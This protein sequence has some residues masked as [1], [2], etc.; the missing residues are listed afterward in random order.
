MLNRLVMLRT[1]T[2]QRLERRQRRGRTR[3]LRIEHRGRLAGTQIKN[4]RN[5]HIGRIRLLMRGRRRRIVEQIRH[6]R[7]ERLDR[8]FG[9]V[10][11]HEIDRHVTELQTDR[12]RRQ[13]E[14]APRRKTHQL[15]IGV[16]DIGAVRGIEITQQRVT[17]GGDGEQ[18]VPLRHGLGRILHLKARDAGIRQRTQRLTADFQALSR[19]D[20]D[21]GAATDLHPPLAR[22]MVTHGVGLPFLL[23]LHG[24][25][26]GAH[27]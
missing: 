19:A 17:L 25:C 3:G 18:R 4:V 8:R 22:R 20:A 9:L 27:A 21:L 16:D 7:R 26:V 15:A 1:D 14:V 23:H 10:D 13:R 2:G 6:M 5:G 24:T 11:A 12:R